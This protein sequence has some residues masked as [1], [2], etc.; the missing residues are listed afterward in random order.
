[1]RDEIILLKEKLDYLND[2][3]RRLHDLYD[4]RGEQI[5]NLQTQLDTCENQNGALF[6]MQSNY[7]VCQRKVEGFSQTSNFNSL[8]TS[9]LNTICNGVI[10]VIS[11]F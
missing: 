7:Q 4:R 2:G 11:E 3:N 1:M 8:K 5:K 6:G 10:S 9:I